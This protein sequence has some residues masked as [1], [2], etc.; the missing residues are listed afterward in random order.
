MARC[1][2]IWVASSGV[3]AEMALA[4]VCGLDTPPR[5]LDGE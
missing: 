1:L 4:A 2:M 5:E 3:V